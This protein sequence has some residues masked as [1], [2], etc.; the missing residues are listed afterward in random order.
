V[1]VHEL[2]DV[3]EQYRRL[4]RQGHLPR[5]APRRF[6]PTR[7]AWLPVLHT[8]RGERHYTAMYSNTAH[9]HEVGATHDWVVIYRDDEDHGGPWTV[10]T[11]GYGPL[12]GRR[13]VRGR[14]DEC[15]QFYP[16]DSPPPAEISKTEPRK[17]QQRLDFG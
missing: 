3:D 16:A 14:E 1:P 10:I 8:E 5:I 11:A 6:N 12:R 7:E 9:A 2:L 13:I 4:A 17:R 15:R